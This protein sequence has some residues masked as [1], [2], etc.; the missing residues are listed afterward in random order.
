MLTK[1]LIESS[2]SDVLLL[3]FIV[4]RTLY[5]FYNANC[6]QL[7]DQVNCNSFKS[8][9]KVMCLLKE[10]NCGCAFSMVP[11]YSVKLSAVTF[12]QRAL[13]SLQESI[14][15]HLFFLGECINLKSFVTVIHCL[16]HA[17]R[18][19]HYRH[20]NEIKNSNKVLS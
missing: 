20:T 10:T 6:S 16:A 13:C 2:V 12:D 1:H 15:S 8:T 4:R 3:F 7:S 18:I 5:L 19:F 9:E 17:T 14:C 11:V